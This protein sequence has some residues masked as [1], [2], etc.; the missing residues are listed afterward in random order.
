MTIEDTARTNKNDDTA[1]ESSQRTTYS[2]EVSTSSYSINLG[3]QFNPTFHEI[4]NTSKTKAQKRRQRRFNVKKYKQNPHKTST[5][6][7]APIKTAM[8]TTSPDHTDATQNIS[9]IPT[10]EYSISSS[11]S[12]ILRPLIHDQMQDND[13]S[14]QL[15]K[16]NKNV[17]NIKHVKTDN[18]LNAICFYLIAISLYTSGW[19]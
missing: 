4:I 19:F 12:P 5:R 13:K 1:S 11:N 14:K 2:M 8:K 3:F 16:N 17:N 7:I 18:D 10:T 15:T 9:T 6:S